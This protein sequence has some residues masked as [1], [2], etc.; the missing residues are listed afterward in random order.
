MKITDDL[1]DIAEKFLVCKHCRE[2]FDKIM[3]DIQ[4]LVIA[5]E[6]YHD[7]IKET[8]LTAEVIISRRARIHSEGKI[9]EASLEAARGKEGEGDSK[10]T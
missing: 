9:L 10:K 8:P 4:D 3:G 6:H 5:A 2:E 7:L 1:R